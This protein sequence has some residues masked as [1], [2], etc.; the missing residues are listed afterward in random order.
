M[1]RCLG[2]I[3]AGALLCVVGCSLDGF[4]A[5]STTSDP[6]QFV[7][8]ESLNHVSGVLQDSLCEAGIMVLA[9]REGQKERL[10]GVT[11]SGKIFCIHLCA[12]AGAGG[13]RTVVRIQ[14]DREPDEQFWRMV[15]RLL[16]APDQE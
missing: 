1:S 15:T 10:A 6:Q 13:K 2:L 8:A 4:L 3:V 7:V 12:G 9:N 16:K 5:P 14:W 11:E